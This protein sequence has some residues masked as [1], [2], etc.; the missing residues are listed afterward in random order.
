MN[1]ESTETIGEM[2]LAKVISGRFE[3][4][5]QN[6]RSSFSFFATYSDLP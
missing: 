6:V 1:G 2:P 3:F 5:Q 4:P